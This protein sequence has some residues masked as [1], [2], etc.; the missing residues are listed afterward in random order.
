MKDPVMGILE[1][2]IRNK[3]AEIF[4]LNEEVDHLRNQILKYETDGEMNESVDGKVIAGILSSMLGHKCEL[5]DNSFIDPDDVRVRCS[6]YHLAK[7]GNWRSKIRTTGDLE[8][9]TVSKDANNHNDFEISARYDGEPLTIYLRP[10]TY[11]NI[12]KSK[13]H[14]AGIAFEKEVGL[15]SI[16]VKS[17]NHD[18]VFYIKPSD[19]VKI[20]SLKFPFF[21][22][23]WVMELS[24]KENG[25]FVTEVHHKNGN[26][27]TVFIFEDDSPLNESQNISRNRFL[28]V[29]V[30]LL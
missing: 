5:W 25:R 15:E 30:H 18:H 3:D 24:R 16:R 19:M 29:P 13:V 1:E 9:I 26:G 4:T 7:I 8:I 6:K 12:S 14:D 20:Q 28:A 21:F 22:G 23:D 27:C 11:G 10:Q 17:K 2:V